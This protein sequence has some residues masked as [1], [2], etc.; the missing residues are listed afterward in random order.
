MNKLFFVF[1]I[2]TLVSCNKEKKSNR[3][4]SGNWKIVTYS[5]V[6]FDGT[7]NQ[8]NSVTGSAHFDKLNGSDSARF[9]LEFKA[10]GNLDTVEKKVDGYY[11]RLALDTLELRQNSSKFLFDINRLFKKDMNLQGGLAPNRK[12]IFIM[13]KD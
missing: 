12:S 3:L 10:F 1:V 9:T 2:L 6:I 5:E 4:L 11:S 8:Y 13:K 7:I